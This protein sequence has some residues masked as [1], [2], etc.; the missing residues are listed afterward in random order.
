MN[1]IEYNML[2]LEQ[3]RSDLLLEVTSLCNSD[4]IYA[5]AGYYEVLIAE[6]GRLG[7]DDA[8]LDLIDVKNSKAL[9]LFI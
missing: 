1:A 9:D 6:C 7:L 3:E 8:R 4:N 5:E 2:Q